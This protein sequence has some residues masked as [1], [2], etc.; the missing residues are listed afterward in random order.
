MRI[1]LPARLSVLLAGLAA[2][3]CSMTPALP[4]NDAAWT[5]ERY[6]AAVW[7]L[8]AEAGP[9][10]RLDMRGLE[11]ERLRAQMQNRY[12][13]LKPALDDGI[14]GLTADGFVALRDPDAVPVAERGRLRALA[15]NENADRS[16][17]YRQIAVRN[18]EP[19]WQ[20]PLREV[21]AQRWIVRAAP[22]WWIRD[23]NGNW[24]QKGVASENA[25]GESPQQIAPD[26][27]E[28][29]PQ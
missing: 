22:L 1:H 2:A 14:I 12:A 28:P 21:F 16:A 13:D 23:A 5:A 11:I 29:E 3:A 24:Q 4:A 6:V 18:D 25:A 26:D 27:G 20:A 9:A 7:N 17:L 10:S 19:A 8:P 15:A